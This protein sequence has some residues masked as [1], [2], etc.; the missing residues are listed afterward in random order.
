MPEDIRPLAITIRESVEA[1]KIAID[2][3]LGINADN[4]SVSDFAISVG[5]TVE[6][7]FIKPGIISYPARSYV[8]DIVYDDIG[9]PRDVICNNFSF[10]YHRIDSDWVSNK[11]PAR[12]QNSNKGSFGKLLMITGSRKYRGA[13]HLSLEAALRGGVGLVNF[14][15]SEELTSELSQKY[16]EAIYTRTKDICDYDQ[17]DV[18]KI[19]RL[20][21]AH[22]A[23]LI[24][25]GSDNTEGLLGLTLALLSSEGGPL[26]LD[27]DA[28]NALSS[29]GEKGAEAI[30]NS[31][32]EVVITPH[33]LEFARLYGTDVAS[34][35]SHRLEVAEK[36]ARENSCTVVLK[37]AGTIITD[38]S[39]VYINFA[40]T[41]ALAKAGSGD[42]LA[43]FVAA[44]LSQK[45]T[46]PKIAAALAVYYH[47]LAGESLAEEYSSYGVTPS[48]LPREIARQIAK[49]EKSR[50]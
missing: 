16:P 44:F 10:R 11:L 23:T 37:G 18:A 43:G 38:A 26:I 32:R 35:Q 6:L 50:N 5:A 20:S 21:A 24:G 33:P 36:F 2:V 1:E 4:G 17:D 13:A 19:V 15:G 12:E 40:G 42:V 34:V 48:D 41:S 25:S 30:K 3:P 14:V 45:N 8:G 31:K 46:S 49:Q 47:A 9:L 28:I 27:A 29:L 39:E 22:T 7:S